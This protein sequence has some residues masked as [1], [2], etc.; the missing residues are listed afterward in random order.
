MREGIHSSEFDLVLACIRWPIEPADAARIEQLARRPLD[1]P[2]LLK[3]V[4]HHQVVSLA[5]RNLQAHAAEQCAA[6]VGRRP[7]SQRG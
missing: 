2:H 1:W 5:Y 3:I 7:Q 6:G 4:H